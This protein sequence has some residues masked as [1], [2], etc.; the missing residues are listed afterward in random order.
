MPQFVKEQV[1]ADLHPSS[2]RTDQK[3]QTVSFEILLNDAM[4]CAALFFSFCVARQDLIEMQEKEA[5]LA[6]VGKGEYRICPAYQNLQVM[7]AQ[8]V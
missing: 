7:P 4:D 3:G 5:K 8:W 1:W 6:V 2:Q